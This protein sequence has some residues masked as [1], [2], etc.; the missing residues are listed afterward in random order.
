VVDGDQA[1]W[2]GGIYALLGDRQHALA[3]LRR[4][5]ALGNLTYPWFQKD[6]NYD[7]LRGDPEYQAIMND[8]RQRSEALRSEFETRPK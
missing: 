4:S 8:V 1:Y 2:T 7:S 5:V 6:K 3:Y